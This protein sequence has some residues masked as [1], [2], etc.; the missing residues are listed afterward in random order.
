[1]P[2]VH[3]DVEV[4]HAVRRD[5]RAEE[6]RD[7]HERLQERRH[8]APP[9]EEKETRDAAKLWRAYR[10]ER[11]GVGVR[12]A[13]KSD[14]RK[15]A[16][17]A[18]RST[19]ETWRRRVGALAE[20]SFRIAEPLLAVHGVVLRELGDDEALVAHLAETASLARKAGES[21]EGLRAIHQARALAAAR[22]EAG[23]SP[24]AP[25]EPAALRC[26][27]DDDDPRGFARHAMSSPLA[28]WRLEEA[29]LLWASGRDG[30][31]SDD[32]HAREGNLEPLFQLIV[33]H[34]PAPGLDTEAPFSFLATLLDRDNFMSA[35]E[36]AEY[37]AARR[38]GRDR[39]LQRQLQRPVGESSV[40]T[41][42]S[43]FPVAF[44][45]SR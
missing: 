9:R 16:A 1:M 23:S 27:P 22:A 25:P 15:V 21:A 32:E 37:G 10:G 3:R 19:R 6:R 17:Q 42:S 28:R 41:I 2:P 40:P 45:A 5:E 8:E 12:A 26:E 11:D 39:Q 13:N 34:V 43:S 18:T 30:Y 38:Q 4:E 44:P 33:D 36:A 20:R 35:A 24:S 7:R 31:A 29:K 14:A